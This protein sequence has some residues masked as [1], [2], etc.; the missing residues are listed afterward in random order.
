M[1]K[2]WIVG[3]KKKY[4]IL[5]IVMKRHFVNVVFIKKVFVRKFMYIE[6]IH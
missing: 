4:V 1:F 6:C 2:I 5:L 3:N